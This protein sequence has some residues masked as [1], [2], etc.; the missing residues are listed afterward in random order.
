MTRPDKGEGSAVVGDDSMVAIDYAE[1]RR[2]CSAAA[3]ALVDAG[4][5]P[6]EL[7]ERPSTG[8]KATRLYSG[9]RGRMVSWCSGGPEEGATAGGMPPSTTRVI[10]RSLT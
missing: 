6:G 1:I 9:D 4:I 7:G 3:Q 8:R 2:Y 5:P 10:P